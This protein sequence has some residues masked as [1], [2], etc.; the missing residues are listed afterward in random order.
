MKYKLNCK[1]F[2]FVL[3]KIQYMGELFTGII[4]ILDPYTYEDIFFF[5]FFVSCFEQR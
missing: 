3:K 5:F 4:L 2:I 1:G